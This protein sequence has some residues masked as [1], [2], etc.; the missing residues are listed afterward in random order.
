MALVSVKNLSVAFGH[1]PLLE[2]ATFQ[3]E[4]G[5]RVTVLG[6]NGCGKS[7]LLRILA[8]HAE[9]GGGA[10]E[11]KPGLTIGY[12]PQDVPAGLVGPVYD[13][14]ASGLSKHGILLADFHMAARTVAD[15]PSPQ[16]LGALEEIQHRVESSGAWD[17]HEAVQRTMSDLTLEPEA[18]FETLSGGLKRRVLL[19]RALVCK[20]D[21]LLLD[22]PTNHLDII[23]IG[24]LERTLL[25]F[26]GTLLLV[27][28][29]RML[30]RHLSTRI[31]EIERAHLTSWA[32]NYDTFCQR[33]DDFLAAEAARLE[34]LD[35]K[36]AR[37]EVWVRQGIKARRTRNE[38]R[39]RAL[40]RM[41]EERAERR[42][43]VGKAR[44]RVQETHRT[45]DMV[46][47]AHDLSF[48]YGSNLIV[49]DFT[50]RIVRKDRIGLLG[51]NGSGKTTLLNLLLKNL[52]PVEGTIRHGSRL[53]VVYFDQLRSTLDF[54]TTVVD[55]V[56]DGRETFYFD[57][58]PTSVYA[59]LED[60]LFS[61]ERA[62]MPVSA[63]SG[64]ERSRLVL[65]R[66]FS[67]PS[68]V[69]VMDEPTNDL[70]VETLE[71]LERLLIDYKG[72]LLL[73][74]HDREFL[75]NVVTS[76]MVLEGNG[77]VVEYGGGYDDWVQQRRNVADDEAPAAKVRKPRVKPPSPRKLTFKENAELAEIEPR[78]EALEAEK[79]L[80][81][82]QLADPAFYRTD[83]E[84]V[85]AAQRRAKEI[86]S[87]LEAT[88][89]R[90][91]ELEDIK[92]AAEAAK[93]K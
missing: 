4:P 49:S 71:L 85:A 91:T 16:A 59:Y 3:L 7:T 63:L 12:L 6:R 48:S 28:H 81:F 25:R 80:L 58:R 8:G 60:F 66:L 74:S 77:Q 67:Q 23:T 38:G 86:D 54:E 68:N 34:N 88:Y 83:G 79:E 65:A 53:Q 22:E 27:T 70:D 62:R 45:G 37:E 84:R 82:A 51:P 72:T 56:T 9:P 17:L 32:C 50:T 14:V 19:A 35:K 36:L 61:R 5:E 46:I 78:I 40:I 2:D 31:I 93:R 18:S 90:W 42:H 30:V 29:D 73:V 87:K 92:E 43:M 76:T 57:G 41:R 26:E 24:W 47:E 64:G 1:P 52:A 69:L 21:L 44:L 10:V 20:P 13:I 11:F 39:V 55:A 15:A 89:V 75:N 33:K